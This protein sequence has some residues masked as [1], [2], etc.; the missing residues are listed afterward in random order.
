MRICSVAILHWSKKLPR[1]S[2]SLSYVFRGFHAYQL[3]I[4]NLAW[5][6]MRLL[7][8]SVLLHFDL[9]LDEE[10]KHWDDQKVYTLWEKRPLMC[11]L[12]PVKP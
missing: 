10:S 12:T 9:R 5:H 3:T 2:K 7:L 8:V 6:E 11:T 1:Q 4:Q